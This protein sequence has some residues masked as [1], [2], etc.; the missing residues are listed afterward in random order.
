MPLPHRRAM[1]GATADLRAA[2][3]L[4]RAAKPERPIRPNLSAQ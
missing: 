4:A 1:L 3:R 2:P